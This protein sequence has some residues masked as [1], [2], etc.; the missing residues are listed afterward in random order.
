MIRPL[1]REIR[2]PTVNVSDPDPDLSNQRIDR[3]ATIAEKVEIEGRADVYRLF[4]LGAIVRLIDDQLAQSATG[5]S[6]LELC[7]TEA[8]SK[9][10]AWGKELDRKYECRHHPI[11]SLV[12]VCLESILY[13]MEYV[14]WNT[15]IRTY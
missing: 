1:I 13:F 7:R 3:P 10:E 12:G 4:N 14:K 8:V 5:K 6:T 2:S 9:L 15:W 11:R